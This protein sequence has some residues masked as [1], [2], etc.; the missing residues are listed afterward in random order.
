VSSRRLAS[1]ILRVTGRVA[2]IYGLAMAVILYTPFVDVLMRPLI[3]R[4]QPARGDVIVVLSAWAMPSGEMNE[5]GLRRAIAAERLYRTGAA[6]SILITGSPPTSADEGNVLIASARFLEEIGIPAAAMAVEDKSFNTRDSAVN[7]ASLARARGW[8][9]VV[10]VTDGSHMLRARLAFE[11]EGLQV[12]AAPTQ[13]WNV[14]GERPTVRFEKFG[15]VVHEYGGLLYYRA[16]GW[17]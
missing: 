6:P 15:A 12:A 1:K 5:S 10:L 13:M 7:V 16:R 3:P 11:H 9:R 17:I 8:T 2:A 4:D 14:Y